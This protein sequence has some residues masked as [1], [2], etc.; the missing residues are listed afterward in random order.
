MVK[1]L[2]DEI[3]SYVSIDERTRNSIYGSLVPALERS[4]TRNLESVYRHVTEWIDRRN[5][6]Y[7]ERFHVKLDEPRS[8]SD[9]RANITKYP[10]TSVKDP[11]ALLLLDE[12][13]RMSVTSD[14]IKRVFSPKLSQQQFRV[15]DYL[16]NAAKDSTDE[17]FD[18]KVLEIYPQIAERL[19]AAADRLVYDALLIP[20]RLKAVSF[21]PHM[22]IEYKQGYADSIVKEV[23]RMLLEGL[24]I[25]N[26]SRLIGISE[27]TV[28]EWRKSIGL[29]SMT[30]M[31][32]VFPVI[33]KFTENRL[34]EAAGKGMR[35]EEASLYAATS[36]NY[37]KVVWR[38]LGYD[39]ISHEPG[40]EKE[41]FEHIR[42]GKRKHEIRKLAEISE[43]DMDCFLATRQNRTKKFLHSGR[44]R[45]LEIKYPEKHDKI[46]QGYEIDMEYREIAKYADVNK[47][48]VWRK[49]KKLGI[50]RGRRL[51]P[52]QKS[53]IE[54][55]KSAE[56]RVTS[57]EVHKILNGQMALESTI[58][59]TMH[60]L[61]RAN[62]KG[63]IERI[64]IRN[65]WFYFCELKTTV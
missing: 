10:D 26:T 51:G 3:L 63:L 35:L 17:G 39:W 6:P 7:S 1:S 5:N 34:K 11:L 65:R 56:R 61:E 59:A 18:R 24:S 9:D 46:L 53:V 32:D 52:A 15:L 4:G 54:I 12:S 31:S 25:K 44:Q 33:T 29:P 50:K 27:S 55:V 49:L 43:G 30:K 20:K 36:T 21:D 48:T 22:N 40:K 47:V 23:Y 13:E 64:K 8:H 41:I 42:K 45:S 19:G 62:K 28:Y 2:V 57:G 38:K 37:V 58:H 60:A 16:L 14:E